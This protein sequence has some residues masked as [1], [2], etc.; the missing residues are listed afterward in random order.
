LAYP[1]LDTVGELMVK[2]LKQQNARYEFSPKESP[3]AIAR[4]EEYSS[5]PLKGYAGGVFFCDWRNGGNTASLE[6]HRF[7]TLSLLSLSRNTKNIFLS[8]LWRAL[9]PVS[10]DFISSF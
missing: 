5:P 8:L 7:S 4:S 1:E 10:S 9:F 2:Q 3:F 6:T